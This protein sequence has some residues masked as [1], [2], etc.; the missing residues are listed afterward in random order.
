[1]SE[2]DNLDLESLDGYINHD[3][4]SGIS[5]TNI[6]YIP[7]D[8]I[9]EDLFP[10]KIDDPDFNLKTASV[11]VGDI[12]LR[13]GRKWGKLRV[14]T[15]S[16]ELKDEL[17]GNKGNK[18]AK[19]MLDFFLTD[20]RPENVS[21]VDIY[22]NVPMV[23]LAMDKQ[24]RIRKVGSTVSPVYFDATA[25]TSGKGPDD[26]A[27]FQVTVSSATGRLAPFYEGEIIDEIIVI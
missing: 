24:G 16:G 11:L 23:F 21:F 25:G 18:K 7:S 26:D 1:M 10:I 22:K 4:T 20:T 5:E 27:G 8:H 12:T 3:I 17:G 19:N 15:E 9:L 6:W 13:D 2:F 14:Q